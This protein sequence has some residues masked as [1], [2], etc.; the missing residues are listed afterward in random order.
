MQYNETTKTWMQPYFALTHSHLYYFETAEKCV[1]AK[2]VAYFDKASF[3]QGISESV[4][5]FVPF[6]SK[7]LL[8]ICCD[9]Q[10]K[11]FNKQHLFEIES[12]VN[13]SMLM[14]T[15]HRSDLIEWKNAFDAIKRSNN[16]LHV[17]QVKKSQRIRSNGFS[18]DLLQTVKLSN[19]QTKRKEHKRSV[20]ITDWEMAPTL[21]K[22]TRYDGENDNEQKDGYTETTKLP[23]PKPRRRKKRKKTG[24]IL[25]VNQRRPKITGAGNVGK[26]D[27]FRS[28]LNANTSVRRHR[29]RSKSFNEEMLKNMYEHNKSEKIVSSNQMNANGVHRSIVSTTDIH[30]VNGNHTLFDIV[31]NV[32]QPVQTNQHFPQTRIPNLSISVTPSRHAS[33]DSM[34]N[35]VSSRRTRVDSLYT[36]ANELS[37]TGTIELNPEYAITINSEELHPNPTSP[38]QLYQSVSLSD[39]GM[40]TDTDNEMDEEEKTEI[41]QL[42]NAAQRAY[43]YFE[44]KQWTKAI[45]EYNIAI[46]A[47]DVDNEYDHDSIYKWYCI[48]SECHRR[49]KH[50]DKA[51]EDTE[52]W[53]KLRYDRPDFNYLKGCGIASAVFKDNKQFAKAKKVILRALEINPK[54]TMFERRLHRINDEL[55]KQCDIRMNEIDDHHLEYDHDEILIEEKNERNCTAESKVITEWSS[56]IGNKTKRMLEIEA[57]KLKLCIQPTEDISECPCVQR[58][59]VILRFYDQWTQ[60]QETATILDRISIYNIVH[61]LK[62]YSLSQLMN[63]FIHIK[64]AHIDESPQERSQMFDYF[65][66]T[67]PKY[68][69]LASSK[70]FIRN[71]RN[72]KEID[73]NDE[74]FEKMYFNFSRSGEAHDII[75]MQILDSIYCFCVHSPQCIMMQLPQQHSSD[76]SEGDVFAAFLSEAQSAMHS[77]NDKYLKTW[78]FRTTLLCDQDA[79]DLIDMNNGLQI[80]RLLSSKHKSHIKPKYKTL[81]RELLNNTISSITEP[82][83]FCCLMKAS[84]LKQTYKGKMWK[85]KDCHELNEKYKI[86]EGLSIPITHLMVLLLYTNN[87]DLQHEMKHIGMSSKTGNESFSK[88]RKRNREIANFSKIMEECI[89]FYGHTNHEFMS[90][91]IFYHGISPKVLFHAFKL[92]INAPT[93]ITLEPSLAMTICDDP[94]NIILQ[95]RAQTNDI[96][97][98]RL[99]D[100]SWLSD[101]PQNNSFL[102]TFSR[103]DV[104]DIITSYQQNQIF[105]STLLLFKRLISGHYIEHL[106]HPQLTHQYIVLGLMSNHS[107]GYAPHSNIPLYIQSLFDYMIDQID[108][109]FIIKSQFERLSTDFRSC[110]FDIDEEETVISGPFYEHWTQ[111]NVR[112]TVNLTQEFEWNLTKQS[113]ML[114]FWSLAINQRMSGPECNYIVVDESEELDGGGTFICFEP[115]IKRSHADSKENVCF[116]IKLKD[117]GDEY[118]MIKVQ[119]NVLFAQIGHTLT[120]IAEFD[121][122]G[123]MNECIAFNVDRL[124]SFGSFHFQLSLRVLSLA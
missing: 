23:A 56:L 50:L 68:D 89:M 80:G 53:M 18:D 107:E 84:I 57:K 29:A 13:S 116:G 62:A 91:A 25:S 39:D 12:K 64:E 102:S 49:L 26:I 65:V 17:Q 100:V 112:L 110:F 14:A 22:N 34:A 86:P 7:P 45:K 9:E 96:N 122:D 92:Q 87:A 6:E 27:P 33:F 37:I 83:W 31:S 8:R 114:Q 3:H 79:N 120:N 69:D 28:N 40:I 72:R 4:S 78:K 43:K 74:T 1:Q 113:E 51:L 93:L 104:L 48:R 41:E 5:G 2:S 71:N 35:N 101:S 105:V 21:A 97:D 76:E 38:M 123:Q 30:N 59:M 77:I 58:L 73:Q 90:N 55:T 124:K 63:D 60:T 11:L 118:S 32:N 117:F 99:L 52:S 16:E 106:I 95:F 44:K 103:F 111:K 10:C 36:G 19:K 42:S 15:A 85:A 98:C 61:Y 20:S 47:I 119:Y 81:K 115:F 70:C 88:F 121:E 67:L 82:E 54:L 24:N 46:N 75:T 66:S 94:N 108:T 109:I